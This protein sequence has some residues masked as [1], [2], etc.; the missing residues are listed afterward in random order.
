MAVHFIISIDLH[1]GVLFSSRSMVR[2]YLG[3]KTP[4]CLVT[5]LVSELVEV[6]SL[7]LHRC[8]IW[9]FI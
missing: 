5:H 2:F 8:V 9:T 3:C 4:G 6:Y 1:L 7:H